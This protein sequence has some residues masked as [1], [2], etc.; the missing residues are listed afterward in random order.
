[1]GI[2]DAIN[3]AWKLAAVLRGQAPD[4]LLDS[5]EG[6]RRAFACKLVETTDRLFS[7]VT[8]EGGFA[9]F[10][11]TRIAPIFASVAYKSENVREYMF[12]LISQTTLNYHER[13]LSAGKAGGVQG[14]DRLPWVPMPGADNYEPLSAIGWQVHVYGKA[15]AD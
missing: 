9:D 2:L 1:T 6:E 8:A 14:G 11:R 12:R 13:P 7:F 4:D 15:Q 3:L 10:V 5:Y